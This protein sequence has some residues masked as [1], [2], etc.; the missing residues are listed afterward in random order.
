VP[1]YQELKRIKR[2]RDIIADEAESIKD[3]LEEDPTASPA[4]AGA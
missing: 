4:T 3:L 2:N 1:A